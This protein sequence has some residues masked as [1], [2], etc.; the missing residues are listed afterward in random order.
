MNNLSWFP[1]RATYSRELLMKDE[2]DRLGV[3]N[4]LPVRNRWVETNIGEEL[5]EV[6]AVH[7]LIFIHST[8][9]K[10][11]ELRQ[12]YMSLEPLRYMTKPSEQ[13]NGN[14]IIRI[15]NCYIFVALPLRLTHLIFLNQIAPLQM[16]Y[17]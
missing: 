14:D 9:E 6:P 5:R 13:G 17:L 15:L 7:N 8:Q 12:S 16:N 2:L 10:I 4:F 11:R 3:E 1:M